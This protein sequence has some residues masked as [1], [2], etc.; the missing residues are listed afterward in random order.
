MPSQSSKTVTA[1]A[2]MDAIEM[3]VADH[4]HVEKLFKQYEKLVEDEGSYNEK[5]ALAATICAE[6]TVHAQ[7]EE[8][9][10]YPAARDVLDDEELIDEA[11]VEH[12][13]AKDLI[14]QLSDMSPDDDLYDAKI[15]VLGELIEHHVEEEEDEMF[16]KLKKAK[17]DTGA[18][19]P[20]MAQRKE[21]LVDELGI[22]AEAAEDREE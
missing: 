22:G 6:L 4:R 20:Q 18:L 10:F 16:P 21:E 13:S 17:L 15:K 7:V 3:L 11:V 2:R 9:I 5:E 19:G 14:A 8:E 1:S 12:A